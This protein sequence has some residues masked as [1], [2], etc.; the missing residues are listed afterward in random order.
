MKNNGT[1]NP[2]SNARGKAPMA[3]V[4][5]PA[6]VMA[7]RAPEAAMPR[8]NATAKS[9]M[10]SHCQVAKLRLVAVYGRS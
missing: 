1:K 7:G 8:I 3:A 2:G 5:T 10:P 4:V 9:K 6:P